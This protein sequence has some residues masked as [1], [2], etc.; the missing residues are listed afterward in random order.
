MADDRTDI[1]NR[2]IGMYEDWA[3]RVGA[4]PW[5]VVS[6]VTASPRVGTNHIHDV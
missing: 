1:L 3:L 4:L 6:E 5:P 2:M